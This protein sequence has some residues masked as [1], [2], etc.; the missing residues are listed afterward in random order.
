VTIAF[1]IV[2]ALVGT[3]AGLV[4][5]LG[6]RKARR[7]IRVDVQP[8][9]Y[10][11]E[12]DVVASGK[13]LRGAPSIAQTPPLAPLLAIIFMIGGCAFPLCLP[14]RTVASATLANKQEAIRETVRRLSPSIDSRHWQTLRE[15]FTDEVVV[16]Y[17]SL[18]GGYAQR[19]S[20]DDLIDNWSLLLAPLSATEHLI[21]P[22][23]VDVG[24]HDARA[25]CS[26]R[27]RHLLHGAPG[28]DE[29][30]VGGRYKITLEER[31]G[32]WLIRTLDL[33]TAYQKGNKNILL[34]AF[35]RNPGERAKSGL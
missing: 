14:P 2:A 5:A 22:I 19:Q 7:V 21:G 16:D 31:G 17:T 25:N 32:H 1:A 18:F 30:V 6:Q 20:I 13:H 12:P 3:A 29:W 34:E 4:A 24:E 28:G 27:I 10:R 33:E 26:V 15:I 8:L 9:A 11:S 35:T 23:T